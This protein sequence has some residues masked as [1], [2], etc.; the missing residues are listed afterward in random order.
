MSSKIQKDNVVLENLEV[1]Y[2]DVNAIKP[3]AYN[4][5]RQSE[6]EFE[7]LCRSIEEDGF[8]QPCVIRKSDNMI[9]DGEHRWRAAQSIGM[10]EIP[11]VLT[12]M[13]EAQMR[14]ATLRHNR[15][16]GSEDQDL[17]AAVLKDLAKTDYL[18]EAAD[19]LMLADE[20]VAK[21]TEQVDD[22]ELLET[23]EFQEAATPFQRED[24][25]VAPRHEVIASTAAASDAM[26][27][28]RDEIAK[29]KTD[30][31]KAA[32]LRDMNIF[33]VSLTFVDEEASI[34]RDALGKNA[35]EG[36][37]A[38]CVKEFEAQGLKIEDI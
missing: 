5:N 29:L 23:P 10:K 20:E 18:A 7:L 11:V 3:N 34:V 9:V 12:E 6:H 24:G 25:S 27:A 38:L 14:I 19:S 13:T 1:V 28:Q 17:A 15:A 21:F 16:R 37:L 31:D 35:A 2:M 33:K 30:E 36:I 8:T 4:P 22:P 32:Y 26:R